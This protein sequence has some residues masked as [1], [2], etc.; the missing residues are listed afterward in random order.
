MTQITGNAGSVKVPAAI[1]LS[2]L[3]MLE[4]KEVSLT[5]M[6]Q[7]ADAESSEKSWTVYAFYEDN[8]QPYTNNFSGRT[9]LE[10]AT[11]ATVD[12]WADFGLEIRILGV[13]VAVDDSNFFPQNVYEVA[14]MQNRFALDKVSTALESPDNIFA[15]ETKIYARQML[16]AILQDTTLDLEDMTD[17]EVSPDS[18][19]FET[20]RSYVL[21]PT[22]ALLALCRLGE[23]SLGGIFVLEKADPEL[24]QAFYHVRA[25]C[26]YFEGSVNSFIRSFNTP[27]AACS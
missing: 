22:D 3:A 10:A 16:G 18:E 27:G 20:H 13:D 26:K 25:M 17:F 4:A 1:V 23:E 12:R 8:G 5:S 19:L 21:Q 11:N 7:Y 6:E 9:A 14:L 15:A 24:A 2:S